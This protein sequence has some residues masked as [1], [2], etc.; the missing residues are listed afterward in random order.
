MAHSVCWPLM[1]VPSLANLMTTPPELPAARLHVVRVAGDVGFAQRS[2]ARVAFEPVEGDVRGDFDDRPSDIGL[3]RFGRL[4]FG[5]D[6]RIDRLLARLLLDA[7]L[8]RQVAVVQRPCRDDDHERL[9]QRI[10]VGGV[11]VEVLHAAR[12]EGANR[13]ALV[14]VLPPDPFE[15]PGPMLM[16]RLR[17]GAGDDLGDAGE[18]IEPFD[19]ELHIR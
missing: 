19:D 5:R 4:Q 17:D 13:R 1:M 14:P 9:L 2:V 15:F 12:G 8:R 16:R 10:K 6:R 11:D 3:H 18:T 7:R